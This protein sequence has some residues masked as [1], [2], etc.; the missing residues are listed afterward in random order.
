MPAT[1]TSSTHFHCTETY[2]AL[3]KVTGFG[4]VVPEPGVSMRV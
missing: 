4:K 1:T 3:E 2:E